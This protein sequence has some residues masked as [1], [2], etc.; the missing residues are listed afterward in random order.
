VKQPDLE[1]HIFVGVREAHTMLG[2]IEFLLSVLTSVILMG[3]FTG[4]AKRRN[5]KRLPRGS[6]VVEGPDSIEE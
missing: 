3:V 1:N 6:Y 5:A 2:R 4:L